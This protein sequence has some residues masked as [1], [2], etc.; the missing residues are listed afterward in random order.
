MRAFPPLAGAF[1]GVRR[2]R[3]SPRHSGND[4]IGRCGFPP[5]DGIASPRPRRRAGGKARRAAW[6]PEA[7]GVGH[8]LV[9]V[10]G[11]VVVQFWLKPGDP[12]VVLWKGEEQPVE[13]IPAQ[14]K[15]YL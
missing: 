9:A 12:P 8:D 10:R 4:A 7:R 14:L 6:P 1:A 15:P 2:S 3:H 13:R 11:E 5:R